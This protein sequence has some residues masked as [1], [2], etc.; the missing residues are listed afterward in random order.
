M[1]IKTLALATIMTLAVTSAFASSK[2][3][4]VRQDSSM[5]N[6]MMMASMDDQDYSGWKATYKKLV[7]TPVGASSSIK[8]AMMMEGMEFRDAYDAKV[9][10][11]ML[12]MAAP[13]HQE[14]ARPFDFNMA[15]VGF[16]TKWERVE[17][18]LNTYR[19]ELIREDEAR[20]KSNM[21]MMGKPMMA[22]P[23][24]NGQ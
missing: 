1:K 18:E 13:E 8:K 6:G 17:K 12:R 15:P 10:A 24:P 21:M 19:R 2:V 11:Y 4:T 7:S 14:P 16:D 5:Q 22:P 3:S 20:G 23:A 9:Y